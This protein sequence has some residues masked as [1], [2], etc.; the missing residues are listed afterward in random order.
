ML[1]ITECYI[2]ATSST[3]KYGQHLSSSICLTGISHKSEHA[4]IVKYEVYITSF[5][6]GVIILYASLVSFRINEG[7]H[8]ILQGEGV[9]YFTNEGFEP[10]GRVEKGVTRPVRNVCYSCWLDLI[11][12]WLG[13]I[14]LRVLM[15][16]LLYAPIDNI[17]AEII[18]FIC[19]YRSE[20]QSTFE[21]WICLLCLYFFQLYQR[22]W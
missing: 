4:N 8:E 1:G 3:K 12:F 18:H 13:I 16:I 10:S 7:Y 14:K 5:G 11:K 17:N 21:S 20:E 2:P 22:N 19:A 15:D 6:T 9:K